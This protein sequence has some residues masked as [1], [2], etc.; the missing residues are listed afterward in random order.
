MNLK[1]KIEKLINKY[2]FR[3]KYLRKGS[4]QRCG[5][6]CSRIYV[7]HGKHTVNTEKE[8]QILRHLHPFYSYLTVEGVDDI[9]LIFSCANFD[10]ENHICKIHK[11]RPA[12]CRRYPD[13]LIFSM[14]AC[15]SEGCGYSF[16]PIDKFSDVLKSIQKYPVKNCMIFTDNIEIDNSDVSNSLDNL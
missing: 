9:G 16:S 4:C 8:F 11:K 5:A 3:K 10:K 7:R 2:I 13:E 6:C 15:L 14:G 1:N 12:I